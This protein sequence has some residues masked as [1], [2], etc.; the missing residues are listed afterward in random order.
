MKFFHNA[1]VKNYVECEDSF[2]LRKQKKII[3]NGKKS[4]KFGAN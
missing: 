4:M 2:L 1:S 3:E